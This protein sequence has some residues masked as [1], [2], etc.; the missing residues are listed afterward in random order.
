MIIARSGYKWHCLYDG[1]LLELTDGAGTALDKASIL[2]C[3]MRTAEDIGYC[4]SGSNELTAWIENG[5]CKNKIRTAVSQTVALLIIWTRGLQ[6]MVRWPYAA[7][8][9]VFSASKNH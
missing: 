2:A 8:E 6:T 5:N 1:T 3:S 7:F 4:W 9:D